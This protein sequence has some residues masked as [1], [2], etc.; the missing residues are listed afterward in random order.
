MSI[1][2]LQLVLPTPSGQKYGEQ[3][4]TKAALNIRNVSHITCSPCS[5]GIMLHPQ[6]H[7]KYVCVSVGTWPAVC[8]DTPPAVSWKRGSV[9]SQ[10]DAPWRNRG[11][12][13]DPSR[14]PSWRTR[15]PWLQSDLCPSYSAPGT[16]I[17]LSWSRYE[18][19]GRY[20]SLSLT[21]VIKRSEFLK[22]GWRE[23]TVPSKKLTWL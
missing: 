4:T 1:F 16:W 9:W 19:S 22:N 7:M 12:S 23:Q 14:A 11:L 21:A 6:I 13:S 3:N 15:S 17:R 10:L 2:C 5:V 18:E 8:P 20:I